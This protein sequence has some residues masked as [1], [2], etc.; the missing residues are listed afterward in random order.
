MSDMEILLEMVSEREVD[1]GSASRSK[2]NAGREAALDE[3]QVA[4][5]EMAVALPDHINVGLLLVCDLA[6][7]AAPR[8]LKMDIRQISNDCI[9]G[10]E[11]LLRTATNTV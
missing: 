7:C 6:Q 5:R 3:R 4:S 9:G 10:L 2:L 1:E 8:W 11:V